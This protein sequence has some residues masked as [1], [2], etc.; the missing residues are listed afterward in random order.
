MYL[1]PFSARCLSILLSWDSRFPLLRSSL[2]NILYNSLTHRRYHS[3]II[4]DNIAYKFDIC[5][6]GYLVDQHLLELG[7]DILNDACN[8]LVL[9]DRYMSFEGVVKLVHARI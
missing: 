7:V 5:V 3:L 1:L 8:L 2:G 9:G 4:L 6:T